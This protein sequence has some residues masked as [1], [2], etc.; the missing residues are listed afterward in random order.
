[1]PLPYAASWHLPLVPG[2]NDG[3]PAPSQENWPQTNYVNTPLHNSDTP[4]APLENWNTNSY[5]SPSGP[6]P[7]QDPTL[8]ID[9]GFQLTLEKIKRE[10]GPQRS[11]QPVDDGVWLEISQQPIQAQQAVG[12][13]KEKTRKNVEPPPIVQ[14]HVNEIRDPKRYYLC[15]PYYFMI[16]TLHDMANTLIP[17]GS[18]NP[19]GGILVSS[20][21]QI[22]DS[23]N[24][25]GAFFAFPDLQVKLVG[26]HKLNFSLYEL[27]KGNQFEGPHAE[28]ITSVMSAPFDC[29][30]AKN[31]KS[32]LTSTFLCKTFNDQ[33]VKIRL[34]KETRGKKR[35]REME[36]E[37]E[38]QQNARPRY[39]L[40]EEGNLSQSQPL[41]PPAHWPLQRLRGEK[42]DTPLERGR[43]RQREEEPEVQPLS[44]YPPLHWA[45][46]SQSAH[47]T[48]SREVNNPAMSHFSTPS[49]MQR[50]Q[51]QHASREED[52]IHPAQATSSR[53]V[54]TQ[55]MSHFSTPSWMQQAQAQPAQ[56][57]DDDIEPAQATSSRE[58]VN[59]Q[60]M[61]HF[62]APSWMQQTQTQPAQR[63]G[64][65]IQPAQGYLPPPQ[66]AQ[67]EESAIQPTSSFSTSSGYLPP[68]WTTYPQ[69]APRPEDDVQPTSYSTQGYLPPP[70][71]ADQEPLPVRSLI[72]KPSHAY[73]TLG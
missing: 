3:P 31:F 8:H 22:K 24:N 33:G 66:P 42:D 14:L 17:V 63:G 36:E 37:N 49:W 34:H 2:P 60:A 39:R 15:N 26:L 52:D 13:R 61:S 16:T 68:P 58:V 59:T 6:N 50:T 71:P 29:R 23:R 64:D 43:Q 5:V 45:R 72:H 44:L 38:S 27:K 12:G 30:V 54:P 69:S 57:S 1:M 28:Y 41:Y 18:N 56:R 47:A 10:P 35:Q 55:A 20:P 73:N 53:E 32:Q 25:L 51:A 4:V 11:V 9:R 46:Q 70:W 40:P 7:L 62:P 21:H 65:D 67:R 19:L 48:A